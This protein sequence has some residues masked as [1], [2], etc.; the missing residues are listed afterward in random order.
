[1]FQKYGNNIFWEERKTSFKIYSVVSKNKPQGR[2]F[3]FLASVKIVT[4]TGNKLF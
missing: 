1:M 3:R 2:S 4:I